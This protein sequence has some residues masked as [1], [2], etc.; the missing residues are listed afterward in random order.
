MLKLLRLAITLAVI[1]VVTT[2][3]LP[4]T[5]AGAGPVCK[6]RDPRTKIC[7][8]VVDPPR[9]PRTDPTDDG[10]QGDN[11]DD[12][13]ESHGEWSPKVECYFREMVP[14]PPPDS[15][16]WAG[17]YPEGAVYA[18]YCPE[19]A[20]PPGRCETSEADEMCITW[21]PD[22]PAEEPVP[23]VSAEELAQQAV[24]Q[25]ALKA[26]DI[27]IVPEA[28]SDRLGLVGMPVW[29]WT[30]VNPHTW[31]P[32]SATAA[33]GGL[34]VTAKAHAAFIDWSMGDGNTR[35][36]TTPG[37]PYRNADGRTPSPDCGHQYAR[38]STYVVS[39]ST[40]W[41]VEW[42]ASNGESGT[43]AFDLEDSVQIRVGESQGVVG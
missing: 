5:P 22:E 42:E 43:I 16:L 35:R 9:A 1:C 37:T 12:G 23:Q 17:H 29:M 11:G 7:I 34:S 33:S 28:R 2:L 41:V 14:P 8:V 36:C 10:D 27:G 31:G 4:M 20:T 30:E 13:D 26:P 39:G 40:H 32:N 21:M 3:V 18:L 6:A 25:M 15:P 24:D 19:G 38:A